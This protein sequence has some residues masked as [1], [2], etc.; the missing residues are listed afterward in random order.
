DA[1]GYVHRRGVVHRDVKPANILLDEDSGR[2]LLADFGVAHVEGSADTSLTQPGITIGTPGYMAPEQ[3]AGARVDGRSDLYSLAA[4][5]FELLTTGSADFKADRATLARTLRAARPELSTREAAVLVAPLAE[6]PDE[7][8]G[9]AD[10]WITA[11]DR[12][13]PRWW[14]RPARH[15]PRTRRRATSRSGW[16]RGFSCRAACRM[17]DRRSR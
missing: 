1:L 15:P 13:R 2:A 4:V 17:P 11:L 8:P 12:T 14:R 10:A 7:R 5:A 3:V 9:S 6:R 16:G